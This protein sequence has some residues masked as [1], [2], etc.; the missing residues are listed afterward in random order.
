[1]PV[2][3][4]PSATLFFEVKAGIKLKPSDILR[5]KGTAP[6][7]IGTW[8]AALESAA[9]LRSSAGQEVILAMASEFM[10]S[11]AT[12]NHFN[13]I[14]PLSPELVKV[15]LVTWPSLICILMAETKLLRYPTPS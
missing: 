13:W 12:A 8:Y 4:L 15:R 2:D 5:S 1:M 11:V 6:T 7:R 14:W 3:H 9:L 10:A